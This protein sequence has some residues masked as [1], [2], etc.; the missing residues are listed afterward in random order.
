VDRKSLL[1]FAAMLSGG[2]TLVVDG[3][4]TL[5]GRSGNHYQA[6]RIFVTG[7]GAGMNHFVGRG[8]IISG[9]IIMTLALGIWRDRRW[10]W[11]VGVIF[12]LFALGGFSDPSVADRVVAVCGVVLLA[13]ALIRQRQTRRLVPTG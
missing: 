2:I 13:S 1:A 5:S 9:A 12:G 8:E 11:I 10:G 7:G 3:A 4:I 6:Y